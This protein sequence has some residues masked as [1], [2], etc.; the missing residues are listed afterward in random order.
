MGHPFGNLGQRLGFRGAPHYGLGADDAFWAI[1][2]RAG[3]SDAVALTIEADD[4]HGASVPVTTGLSGREDG[5]FAAFGCDVADALPEAAVA[6]SVGAAEEVDGV[7]SVVGS[8]SKLHGAVMLVAEGQD[9]RP[10]AK[11]V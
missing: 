1:R 4:E 9:V 6:E 5:W 2:F 10:H 11:R 3:I 7:V 8:Q